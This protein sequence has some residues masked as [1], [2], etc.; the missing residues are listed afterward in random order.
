MLP[1]GVG[2]PKLRGS[3]NVRKNPAAPDAG[4]SYGAHPR[5][6]TDPHFATHPQQ[7][8]Y[9]MPHLRYVERVQGIL[10]AMQQL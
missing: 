8:G 2:A 1:A 10:G 4:S 3:W 5:A 6:Y 7:R 9:S